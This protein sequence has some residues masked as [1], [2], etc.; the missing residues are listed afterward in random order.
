MNKSHTI[1]DETISKV[2]NESLSFSDV[3]YGDH[4]IGKGNCA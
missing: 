1:F 4:G 2:D 3:S